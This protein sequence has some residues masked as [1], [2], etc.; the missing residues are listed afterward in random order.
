MDGEVMRLQELRAKGFHCS[1]IL[2]IM[3]L[4]QQGKT[5]P[6]LVRAM[7][8]LANGLGHCG[9]LCGALT[10]AVCLL[11]LY[12]GRG[13]VDEQENY[14][15]A[16]MIQDLIVWFEETFGKSY[17][18]TDCKVILNDDPWNRMLRCPN[19]V[20]ETY[21]K[22]KELLESNGFINESSVSS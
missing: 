13:T 19:M 4:E 11:S 10:G 1:Q 3:G 15:L 2:I 18:G 14:K 8:G 5:N 22:T 20:I 7:T 17:G 21:S 6:D 16:I 12:A 9:K